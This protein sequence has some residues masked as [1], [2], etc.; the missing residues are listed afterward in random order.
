M[1]WKGQLLLLLLLLSAADAQW[2][3]YDR[4]STA[5]PIPTPK[6]D[7]IAY[8][9]PLSGNLRLGIAAM[10]TR[11]DGC[12]AARVVAATRAIYD[13]NTRNS[14]FCP[15]IANL[16]SADLFNDVMDHGGSSERAILAGFY[17]NNMVEKYGF[18]LY[19]EPVHGIVGFTTSGAS[20]A[21]ATAMQSLGL[22]MV[23]YSATSPLLSLRN[24]P[25][26]KYPNF[27][28]VCPGDQNRVR[29]AARAMR[30]MGYTRVVSFYC[31]AKTTRAACAAPS[32][33]R[34]L[35]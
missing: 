4:L 20:A 25:A 7:T 12:G 30:H 29:A 19:G 22:P 24:G 23:C 6:E 14:T 13:V 2:D 31:R 15:A 26:L 32:R 21:G 27:F 35:L 3:P 1:M 28:R 17:F 8:Y 34:L 11:R 33:A 9:P 5:G 16:G 18:G 10:L